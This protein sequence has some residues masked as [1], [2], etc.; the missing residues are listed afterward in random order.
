[1][2]FWMYCFSGTGSTLV[3]SPR[4]AWFSLDIEGFDPCWVALKC[5]VFI[6]AGALAE[7]TTLSAVTTLQLMELQM[8]MRV[9]NFERALKMSTKMHTCGHVLHGMEKNTS[10]LNPVQSLN[11]LQSTTDEYYS[12]QSKLILKEQ[13]KIRKARLKLFKITSTKAALEFRLNTWYVFPRSRQKA[14]LM[15]CCRKSNQAIETNDKMSLDAEGIS[16]VVNLDGKVPPNYPATIS[17]QL[18][19]SCESFTLEITSFSMSFTLIFSFFFADEALDAI[20]A[21]Y[22]L[23]SSSCWYK[24]QFQLSVLL[25][26]YQRVCIRIHHHQYQ[27]DHHRAS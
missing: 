6:G 9:E 11:V 7:I 22:G 21:S 14:V 17:N 15:S 13:H 10:R 1:M 4:H 24:C 26:T 16:P 20:L 19:L 12:N 27:H 18:Q 5:C 8:N 25:G 3:S 2:I 23:A